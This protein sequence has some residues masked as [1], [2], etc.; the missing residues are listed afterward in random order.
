MKKIRQLHRGI[1]LALCIW[2]GIAQSQEA[3]IQA[4]VTP[5]DGT[6]Q[7]FKFEAMSKAPALRSATRM[8]IEMTS[9][10]SR[11]FRNMDDPKGAFVNRL[12]Q[13]Q[14]SNSKRAANSTRVQTY[15]GGSPISRTL[16][17]TTHPGTG[18]LCSAPPPP[19]PP[20]APISTLPGPTGNPVPPASCTQVTEHTV[21]TA[22][23][24]GDGIIH[25]SCYNKV[26]CLRGNAIDHCATIS[27]ATFNTGT[28]TT[29]TTTG[30]F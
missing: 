28:T 2:F 1:W 21:C 13:T 16:P 5:S 12:Q 17:I 15:T 3:G 23:I 30:T 29:T 11:V 27:S 4:E 8:L 26:C 22:I 19:T 10:S 24:Y 14:Q 9:K 7:R 18:I 20:P 25:H 6:G